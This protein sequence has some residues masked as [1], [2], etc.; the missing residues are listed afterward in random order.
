[1]GKHSKETG[2]RAERFGSVTCRG[3]VSNVPSS[4][5]MKAAA[6]TR[7]DLEFILSGHPDAVPLFKWGLIAPFG[8]EGSV[9]SPENNQSLD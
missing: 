7:R 3:G 5:L 1:M 9:Q 2:T 4:T 8:I 6:V